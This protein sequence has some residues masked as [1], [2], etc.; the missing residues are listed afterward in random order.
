MIIQVKNIQL[1]KEPESRIQERRFM[2]FVFSK[3]ICETIC[4]KPLTTNAP[5]I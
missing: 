1:I 4:F 2:F 5:I 3:N